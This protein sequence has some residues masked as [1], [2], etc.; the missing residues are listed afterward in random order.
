MTRHVVVAYHVSDDTIRSRLAGALG[1][2]LRRV[3]KSVFEGTVEDDGY[4][5][6]IR[7]AQSVIDPETDSVRVYHLCGRCRDATRVFGTGTVVE[8]GTEDIV[9]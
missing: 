9:L 8:P 2:Y 6:A 5:V 1:G 3:Q 7:E 4:E